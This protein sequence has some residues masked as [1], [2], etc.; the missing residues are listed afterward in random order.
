LLISD[1]NA[2]DLLDM[3]IVKEFGVDGCEF[4]MTLGVGRDMVVNDRL[5]VLKKLDGQSYK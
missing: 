5:A 1:F 2:L 3:H 4:Y